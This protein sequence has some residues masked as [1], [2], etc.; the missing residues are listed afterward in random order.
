MFVRVYRQWPHAPQVTPS[1]TSCP[2][3]PLISIRSAVPFILHMHATWWGGGSRSYVSASLRSA[4][5]STSISLQFSA[6]TAPPFLVECR[7]HLET[8]CFG[9][10]YSSP[11]TN[12]NACK[13]N[14]TSIL[15]C[16]DYSQTLPRSPTHDIHPKPAIDPRLLLTRCLRI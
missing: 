3:Q 4:S 9:A 11:R 1:L 7:L 6:A 12:P 10:M 2:F 5:V 14:G 8:I 15:A 13:Q 16:S